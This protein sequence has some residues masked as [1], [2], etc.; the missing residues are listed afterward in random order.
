MPEVFFYKDL[1]FRLDN[2]L[3]IVHWPNMAAPTPDHVHFSVPCGLA[4]I[5]SLAPR[6]SDTCVKETREA[7]DR[8]RLRAVPVEISRD[9]RDLIE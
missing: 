2:E 6:T 8:L 1:H 7:L 5:R 3:R 4:C 9:D